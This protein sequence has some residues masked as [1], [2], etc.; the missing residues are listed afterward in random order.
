WPWRRCWPSTGPP[1]TSPWRR[2][3]PTSGRA[4]WRPTNACWPRRT[5]RR[6]CKLSSRSGIPTGRVL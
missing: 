3:S 2:R 4:I 6:D 1:A 5:R